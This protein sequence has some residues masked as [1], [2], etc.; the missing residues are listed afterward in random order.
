MSEIL[1]LLFIFIGTA[2]SLLSSFGFLRLPDVYTRSHAGTKSVTLGLLSILTGAFLYFWLK[3]GVISIRLVLG[4]TFVF[5]TAP[6]A[7]HMIARSAYR[8][9]VKLADIS[10]A[11]ELKEDLEKMKQENKESLN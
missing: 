9:G 10:A 6:V 2:L 1:T 3:H 7:G 5:L 11:D 8:S 4:I